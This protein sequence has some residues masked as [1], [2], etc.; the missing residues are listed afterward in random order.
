MGTNSAALRRDNQNLVVFR[1][2]ALRIRVPVTDLDGNPVDVSGA[3]NVIWMCSSEVDGAADITKEYVTGD[4][5]I[6]GT[7]EFT[8][9]LTGSDTAALTETVYWPDYRSA[10][11]N[12]IDRRSIESSYYHEA[13]IIRG[14]GNPYTVVSGRLFVR[15]SLIEGNN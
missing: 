3:E 1:G 5:Q 9:T 11:E 6:G 12:Q 10:T 8:V 4:I 2:D 13:R 7:D 15:S 14:D